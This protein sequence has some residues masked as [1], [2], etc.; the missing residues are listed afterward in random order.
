M[1]L[2][3]YVRQAVLFNIKNTILYQI[4]K[5]SKKLLENNNSSNVKSI[6]KFKQLYIQN[7]DVDVNNTVPCHNFVYAIKKNDL[8]LVKKMEKYNHIQFGPILQRNIDFR[9]NVYKLIAIYGSLNILKY[10]DKDDIYALSPLFSEYNMQIIG[11]HGHVKIMEFIYDQYHKQNNNKPVLGFSFNTINIIN[12]CLVESILNNKI[13]MIKW[14]GNHIT[15]C[16]TFMWASR[17]HQILS[18]IIQNDDI[19]MLELLDGLKII[20]FD[21]KFNY[22][23]CLTECVYYTKTK[24]FYFFYGK[25]QNFIEKNNDKILT[26]IDNLVDLLKFADNTRIYIFLFLE[27]QKYYWKNKFEKMWKGSCCLFFTIICP[28]FALLFLFFYK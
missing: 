13:D 15:D 27:I 23:I 2:N 7:I 17:L 18:H 20:I 3:R 28:I 16:N 1:H 5:L 21:D 8:Q 6:L 9:N 11:M 22:F 14:I 19:E 12:G 24:T 26:M 10:F 4:L 25:T